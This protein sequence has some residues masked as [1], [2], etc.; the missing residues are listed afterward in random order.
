[1]LLFVWIVLY[2]ISRILEW[3]TL[4]IS[5][6]TS[7]EEMTRGQW[8]RCIQQ[9]KW[10]LAGREQRNLIEIEV[11]AAPAHVHFSESAKKIIGKRKDGQAGRE[12]SRGTF[13]PWGPR[14]IGIRII[15]KYTLWASRS[16][17]LYQEWFSVW[18]PRPF[19]RRKRVK[20]FAAKRNEHGCQDGP[21][22]EGTFGTQWSN[23]YQ[24]VNLLFS[25]NHWSLPRLWS[26]KW[27]R[28]KQKKTY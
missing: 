25:Q 15:L 10:I 14:K 3:A 28:R 13:A 4:K 20:T 2:A 8:R 6:K 23:W 27:K 24:S 19:S 1:M 22:R 26:G 12:K 11:A 17:F 21:I 9:S 7:N 16:S 5:T 18:G